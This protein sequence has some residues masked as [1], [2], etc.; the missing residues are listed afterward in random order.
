MMP[1]ID[2]VKANLQNVGN[3]VYTKGNKILASMQHHA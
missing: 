3:L 2:T 1:H